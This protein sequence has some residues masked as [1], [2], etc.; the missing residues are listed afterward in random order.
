MIKV[1]GYP[2]PDASATVGIGALR[3]SEELVI[4]LNLN[5]KIPCLPPAI[6]VF[7]IWK[8]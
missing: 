3:W 6:P 4:S 2:M 7:S 1:S 5:M 8:I